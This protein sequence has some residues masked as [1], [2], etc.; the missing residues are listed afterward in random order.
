[1]GRRIDMPNMFGSGY[2]NCDSFERDEP[3]KKSKVL[4]LHLYHGRKSLNENMSDWGLV[5]PRLKLDQ[6]YWTYGSLNRFYFTGSDEYWLRDSDDLF[7]YD[8]VYYG[9]F[10]IGMWDESETV[11]FD[12]AKSNEVGFISS[13]RKRK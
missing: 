1:M 5:G 9:D 12:E 7:Y 11:L 2:V 6:A 8:G 10:E 3:V 4:A 13:E